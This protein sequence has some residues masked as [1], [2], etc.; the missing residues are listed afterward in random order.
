MKRF[1][2]ILALAALSLACAPAAQAQGSGPPSPSRRYAFSFQ[3]AEIARVTQEILGTSLGATYIIDPGVTGRMSFRL[4]GQM[5]RAQLL[6]AFEAA[7]APYDM[8]IVRNGET[9]TVTPRA[10]ARN[11]ATLTVR[12]APAA[13]AGYEVMAIPLAYATP[14][15]AARAFEA[16][17]STNT[18]V[19]VNDDL[20]LL[21]LGGTRRELE[22]AQQTVALL[23]QSS[24][25]GARLRWV[26]LSNATAEVVAPDLQQVL[27]A[28]NIGGVSVVPLKRLNGLLLMAR[29]PEA[30]TQ[31]LE[32]V[33]RLDVVSKDEPTALWVYRP[34]NLTAEALAVTVTQLV[35][36]EVIAS[37][38][39]GGSSGASS[40]Q[41]QPVPGVGLVA[42]PREASSVRPPAAGEVRVGVNR[43]SNTLLVS[44]PASRWLQIQRILAEVDRTPSQV[45]I[46]AS[47]LEVTL[48]NEFRFGLNWS[49]IGEAGRLVVTSTNDTAGAVGARFPGLSA[50][51]V[52]SDIRAAI[53]AISAKTQVEVL[54]A[55]KLVALDNRPS[56]LQVGDQVPVITEASR[57]TT[58]PN[59]PLRVMTEYRDT[60]VILTVTPR[61]SGANNVLL[62]V[63]QE[64]SSVA[65]TT[66][67]GIDSPTIQQRRLDGTLLLRNNS[68]VA[69]G[70]LISEDKT[71][72]GSGIPL[73]RDIPG[74][75]AL[76]QNQVR[77]RRRTELIVLI[78]ARIMP[79][80]ASTEQAMAELAAQMQEVNRRGLFGR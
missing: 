5:T 46:E 43:E 7:L 31:T 78:T 2:T 13:G 63:S 14:S 23:D 26:E 41:G 50:V 9:L 73:L 75:G 53:D 56:R 79:D 61:V 44:A 62:E 48:N 55:P 65:R 16:I 20:G 12:G 15:E 6:E 67:S 18:V 32:W 10:K 3:D 28:S 76:F 71:V 66:T 39:S 57:D 47:V 38:S 30:L 4:D 64:V 17:G 37:G 19:Y 24:L 25:Q 70:G 40:S 34:L 59:A 42:Q 29:S 22:A 21:V 80:L 27:E 45:M 60:G 35:G 51:Y 68:T 77:D 11:L 1:S 33:A 58:T 74:V 52:D 49:A 72:S 36:G 54:S 8:A 69:L